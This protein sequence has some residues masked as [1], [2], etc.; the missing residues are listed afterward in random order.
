MHYVYV[1][2]GPKQ[3]YIGSTGDLKRRFEEHRD[4][5][6]L[7]TKSRGPWRLVY[8][9]ASLSKKDALARERY[10]KTAWGKRYLKTR[11]QNSE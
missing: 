1:L 4:G 2:R 11:I 9:E 5:R 3:F 6:S 8:Y 10:L 7:A